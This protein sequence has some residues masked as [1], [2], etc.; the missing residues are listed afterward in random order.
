[1]ITK[2]NN[3]CIVKHIIT[4]NDTY[5]L[6]YSTV[7]TNGITNGISVICEWFNNKS[8]NY[9]D[10]PATKNIIERKVYLKNKSERDILSIIGILSDQLV[11]PDDIEDI[12]EEFFS[13]K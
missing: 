9:D 5:R 1:M 13:I 6:S 10:T 11:F 3:L 7:K 12:I 2:E 8:Y 4:D